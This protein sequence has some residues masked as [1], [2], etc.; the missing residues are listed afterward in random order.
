[1]PQCEP[2]LSMMDIQVVNQAVLHFL[3]DNPPTTPEDFNFQAELKAA[4]HWHWPKYD[5]PLK[6]VSGPHDDLRV[7][8]VAVRALKSWKEELHK[9]SIEESTDSSDDLEEYISDLEEVIFN[10]SM[11]YKGILEETD[12]DNT[13][14]ITSHNDD[15]RS[16][17]EKRVSKKETKTIRGR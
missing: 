6:L 16:K 9:A 10:L 1:M 7:K 12:D 4:S 2:G 3:I 17:I 11:Y 13:A 8:M 15:K 14:N 5:E